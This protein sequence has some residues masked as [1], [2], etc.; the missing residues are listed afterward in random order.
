MNNRIN[1]ASTRL[2]MLAR[3]S[4]NTC[5]N[6]NINEGL[7]VL[8]LGNIVS[9]LINTGPR[10]DDDFSVLQG[11][12]FWEIIVNVICM[13]PLY[14]FK[15][16]IAYSLC[17]P[18]DELIIVKFSQLRCHAFCPCQKFKKRTYA[19]SI[20]IKFEKSSSINWIF[21][22]KKKI[23]FEVDFYT[24]NRK[25]N[26][27]WNWLKIQFFELDFSNLIFQKSSTDQ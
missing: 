3:S 1:R 23:N 13:N 19:L 24:L 25:K 2:L 16:G 20:C 15:T 7:M 27:V 18:T 12:C 11:I 21:N 4:S 9:I 22:L 26:P 14:H 6:Y 10:N 8:K 5:Y 17:T